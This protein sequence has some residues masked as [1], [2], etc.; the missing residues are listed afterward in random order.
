VTLPARPFGQ[1][2]RPRTFTA[3]TT[4]TPRPHGSRP[5]SGFFGGRN[6]T[7]AQQK[8][9]QACRSKLPAGGRFGTG[10]RSGSSNPAFAK[11]TQCLAKHGVRFGAGGNRTKFAKAQAA[12]RSLLPTQASSSG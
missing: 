9:F 7:P 6:L 2:D 4:T 8:A 12:C 3:P 1:G 11:Y 5:R 10:A